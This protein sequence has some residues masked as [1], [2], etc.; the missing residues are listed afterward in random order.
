[1]ADLPERHGN[2]PPGSIVTVRGGRIRISPAP[3]ALSSLIL[4]CNLSSVVYPMGFRAR[5]VTAAENFIDA[6]C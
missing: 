3:E 4:T 5:L 1:M 6:R 2:D